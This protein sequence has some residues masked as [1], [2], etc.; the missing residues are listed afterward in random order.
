MSNQFEDNAT[1]ALVLILRGKNKARAK[2][3][4]DFLYS[5]YEKT[6]PQFEDLEEITTRESLNDNTKPDIA[7]QIQGRT[8]Y[9]YLVDICLGKIGMQFDTG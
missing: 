6:H 7:A 1:N 9:E 2:L 8:A 4:F 3:I 5:K